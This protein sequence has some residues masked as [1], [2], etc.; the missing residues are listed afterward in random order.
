MSKDKQMDVL[1]AAY[2]FDDLGKKDYDAVMDLVEAKTISVQGVVLASKDENGEM[3]VIEAGDHAVRKG[4]TMVGGAGLVVGLFAPPLL[5][6]TAVGAGSARWPASS[7]STAS[8]SG[9]GEKLDDTSRRGLSRADRDLRVGRRRCGRGCDSER[10]QDVR[11]PHRRSE[12]EGAQGRPRGGL[13]RHG[14]RLM[15]TKSRGTVVVSGNLHGHRRGDRRSTSRSRG[16][17]SSQASG[18]R[19][20]ATAS[21]R[22]PT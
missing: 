19:P 4:A 12:R 21:R 10:D 7:P 13:C 20:T 15:A 14:R 9:I 6:A 3:Q 16:S 5:A 22:R 17:G 11:G 1:I 8:T 2:L 18:A